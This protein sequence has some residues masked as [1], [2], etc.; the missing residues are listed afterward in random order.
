MGPVRN[1][2]IHAVIRTVL[3][4]EYGVAMPVAMV[5]G[6]NVVA[7]VIVTGFT[8]WV[9]MSYQSDLGIGLIPERMFF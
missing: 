6:I 8:V 9:V 3:Y 4:S 2:V 7:V 1:S 5:R